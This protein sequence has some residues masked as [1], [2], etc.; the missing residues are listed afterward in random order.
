MS[1][2]NSVPSVLAPTISTCEYLF[3]KK[4]GEMFGHI[5]IKAEKLEGFVDECL[6]LC[7]RVHAH[8]LAH[9]EAYFLLDPVAFNHQ[10]H[11]YTA[12]VVQL[13]KDYGKKTLEEKL[14]KNEDNRFLHLCFFLAH[15]FIS[16]PKFLV[17][18]VQKALKEMGVKAPG[19]AKQFRAFLIDENKSRERAYREALNQQFEL[20]LKAALEIRKGRGLIHE[21]LSRL[22]NE[23]LRLECGHGTSRGELY[24][25][26]KIAGVVQMLET[27][28]EE[29]IPV[30]LKVRALTERGIAGT[31]VAASGTIDNETPTMVFEAISSVD[32]THSLHDINEAARSCPSYFY[33]A[34]DERRLHKQEESCLFC[35]KGAEIDLSPLQ[36]RIHALMQNP[37]KMFHALGADFTRNAQKMF[38]PF[39]EDFEK[40]PELSHIYHAAKGAIAGLGLG[41]ESPTTLTICHAFPD[42]GLHALSEGEFLQSSTPGQLL[43]ERGIV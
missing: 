19:T 27:F 10:C 43:E 41:M 2:E 31:I 37:E 28:K 40:Y 14:E 23:N 1:S 34:N 8:I 32:G 15:P 3:H 18:T 21:E 9:K 39:F 6:D 20:D 5:N 12:K 42:S 26:P 36:E 13:M 33:R 25:Y 29:K 38:I 24:T 4:A 22:A 7:M 35:R 17:Q 16:N 11:L 30:V